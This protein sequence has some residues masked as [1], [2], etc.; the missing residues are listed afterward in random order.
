[1]LLRGEEEE[2][3]LDE[4]DRGDV[5]EQMGEKADG[6]ATTGGRAEKQRKT[7]KAMER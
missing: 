5:S 6:M 4:E 7:E 3:Q 2:G 1:M